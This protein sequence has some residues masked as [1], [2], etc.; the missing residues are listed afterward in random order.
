MF[1]AGIN[2]FLELDGV[3]RLPAA[4]QQAW[5]DNAIGWTHGRGL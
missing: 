2:R 1:D 5:R 3:L 4:D